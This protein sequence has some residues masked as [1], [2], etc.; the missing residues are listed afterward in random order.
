MYNSI[1]EAAEPL[2]SKVI[3]DSIR[4][5]FITFYNEIQE[6]DKARSIKNIYKNK[7]E[8]SAIK[9]IREDR[10]KAGI[11]LNEIVSDLNKQSNSLSGHY[12]E[13][14]K[15]LVS[16]LFIVTFIGLIASIVIAFLT[17]K[18][19][20]K[21]ITAI[22]RTVAKIYGGEWDLPIEIHSNDEFSGLAEAFDRMRKSLL[23][24]KKLLER[25][26]R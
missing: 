1:K 11:L 2:T 22:H 18:Q 14:A 26:A 15:T 25:R 6:F 12:Q 21:S 5:K 16:I 10:D 9:E 19:V 4:D 13:K 23:G 24:A 17:V 20:T 3:K 7:G 8:E